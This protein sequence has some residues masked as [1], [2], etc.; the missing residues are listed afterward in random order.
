M[1]DSC[2]L[3]K[4]GLFREQKDIVC[5]ECCELTDWESVWSEGGRVGS[6]QGKARLIQF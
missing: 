2:T 4:L 5:W 3:N 1:C 6:S